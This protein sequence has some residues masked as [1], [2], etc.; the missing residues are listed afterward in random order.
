MYENG[1]A[2]SRGLG[3]LKGIMDV[4]RDMESGSM[5][6]RFCTVEVCS[7]R[8]RETKTTRL[9]TK[10]SKLIEDKQQPRLVKH[11]C[12]SVFTVCIVLAIDNDMSMASATT[13]ALVVQIH[14]ILS[15]C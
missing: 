2:L 10:K 7:K 8:E 13:Y 15:I 4:R 9:R 14:I 6:L 1:P 11:L 5:Q 12:P 3:R